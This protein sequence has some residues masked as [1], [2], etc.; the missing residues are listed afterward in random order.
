MVLKRAIPAIVMV[1]L[2]ARA[3]AGQEVATRIVDDPEG[4]T[5]SVLIGP[6]DLPAMAMEGSHAG[7]GDAH[8][9][10][11]GNHFFPPV[12]TVTIP[13]DAYL[14]AFRYEVVDGT[15]RVLPT[16]LVHHINFI[17]PDHRELFL[18]ISQRMVAAGKETGSQAMPWMLFGFPVAGGQR[19]VVSAMLHNPLAE[20][21]T[22]VTVR[23]HFDYV[24]AGRPWPFFS[25]YPFQLD[26]AFPAGDKSFDLPP[27]RSSKSYEARPALAG[28]ILAIGGHTHELA[29]G[30]KFEDVTTEEVIWEGQPIVDDAGTVVGMPVGRLY[31]KLGTRID[32]SHVYR[33]TVTYGNPTSDTIPEGGMGVVGGIFRPDGGTTWPAADSTNQTYVLDRMH[34]MREVRGT[35]ATILSEIASPGSSDL[36]ARGGHAH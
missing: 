19:M 12:G 28:R 26:V 22:G 11:S 2:T 24:A 35:L 36:E 30:L 6:I 34:Y 23:F 4:G 25:V 33:V 31:R 3:A 29:V 15:G 5:M 16:E 10:H 21:F 20:D 18:P 17:D 27:G 13:K 9:G 32:P 1:L 8:A 7:H 14:H